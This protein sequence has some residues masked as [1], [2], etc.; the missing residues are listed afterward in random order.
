MH[1]NLTAQTGLPVFFCD[2]HSPRQHAANEQRNRLVRRY[3]PKGTDF[4]RV[5]DVQV[6]R[7]EKII[8]NMPMKVF[9]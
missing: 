3:F 5:T 2:P 1:L 6:A 8:N 7:V 9:G 4:A